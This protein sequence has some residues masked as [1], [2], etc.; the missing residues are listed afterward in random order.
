MNFPAGT[1]R[2]RT[3]ATRCRP[4]GL[5]LPLPERSDGARAHAT[6]AAS[7]AA[8][9]SR[10][11]PT[12]GSPARA[13]TAMIV[14]DMKGA[15]DDR[16]TPRDF[17]DDKPR[18]T[19]LPCRV[20]DSSTPRPRSTTGAK[21][22]DCVDGQ[23]DGT[24]DLDVAKWLA[25]GA[26]SLEG[27][28]ALGIG[29]PPGPQTSTE[30]PSTRRSTRPRTSTS[31]TRPSSRTRG[32]FLLATDERGG[33]VT[34]PGASCPTRRPTTRSATAASTP[35]AVDRAATTTP[36]TA[37][38]GA[39]APYAE[40]SEGGKAIYRAPIRTAA[41]GDALHRARVPAD[42]GPEPDLHGLVLAGHAGRRLHRERRTARSTSR[43]PAT[44]SR[45][46]RTSGS[47]TSSRSQQNPDGTFT[48]WGATGDFNLG[49]G[50]RN[51]ID[52][53]KV[54]L[55]AP[56][57]AARR[58]GHRRARPGRAGRRRR[59][60]R[61]ATVAGFRRVGAKRAKRGGLRLNFTRQSSR[62][63]RVD[64]FRQSRA[65]RSRSS[66]A[67]RRSARASA[68]SPG[69][70]A[71]CATATTSC[72][73]GP[74]SPTAART[75][76]ASRCGAPTGASRCGPRSS[77]PARAPTRR[78]VPAQPAGV[79]R[80]A[81]A[82]AVRLLPPQPGGRREGHRHAQRQGRAHHA[83][84]ALRGRQGRDAAASR[85]RA[86]RAATTR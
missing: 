70:R 77:A 55:P 5:P 16:G 17:T 82:R 35:T 42:P 46:T 45:P 33:G 48:Y 68:P 59:G 6:R 79:R 19:P 73:S 52:V 58:D 56:P 31:T 69:R 81:E 54:T 66:S 22:T 63:V 85:R 20:R 18:G 15:F 53:Y 57:D 78:R 1:T 86:A 24:D 40:D 75:C 2:R 12:T 41:A 44:S 76:G 27:V 80:Q 43:R 7:T 71:A 8:T 32:G 29:L 38:R 39:S 25:A 11:I 64:V 83:A 30:Q 21:V 36:A 10:S 14:F 47:R 26:P 3:S 67:S 23:G 62:S 65:A 61:C 50:G 74:S 51:A 72:A 60:E 9:S 34:P 84:Q 49:G 13:A 37:E 28:A 4:A